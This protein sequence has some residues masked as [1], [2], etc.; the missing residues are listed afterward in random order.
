[1]SPLLFTLKAAPNQ[2]LDL[3]PLLPHLLAGKSG[4]EIAATNLA[5]TREELTVGDIFKI[6]AGATE[7]IRLEGGSERFDGIGQGLQ[8]G[9]IVMTGDVGTNAGRK[10]TGGELVISGNVGPYAGSAMAGGR[11]EIIGDAGD[12]LAA[13]REGEI[14]GMTG[15]LFVLR[16]TAGVRAGDR[17]RRGTILIEGDAGDW[18]GSRLIAG[19]LIVLGRTG[20]SP[21]YLMRRGTIVLAKPPELSATFVDCGSFASS[22]P[23][24]FGRFLAAE[25]RGA[26]R[27]FRSPLRRF[28]GDMAVLGKG[29]IFVPA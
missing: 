6:R 23:A 29:E 27:L 16:G 20:T 8:Q 19:T 22:F 15:G 12:F 9:R 3:S 5:T 28:G 21:G 24:V 7:E 13:P 11:L 26:A 17:L 18:L 14:H 25:S 2:R 1:V 10:M 4:K